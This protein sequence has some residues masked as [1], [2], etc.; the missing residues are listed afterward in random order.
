MSN[1]SSFYACLWQ[2]IRNY[3]TGAKMLR[4]GEIDTVLD[5]AV[6]KII[7]ILPL[8]REQELAVKKFAIGNDGLRESSNWQRKICLLWHSSNS[9]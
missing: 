3:W 8:R 6:T 1:Y 7:D 4:E 9:V 2:Q 5:Q